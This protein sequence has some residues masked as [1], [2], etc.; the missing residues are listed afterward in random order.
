MHLNSKS[1]FL[2]RVQEAFLL[3]KINKRTSNHFI[4]VYKKF[5]SN[6]RSEADEKADELLA[7]LISQSSLKKRG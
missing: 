4:S 3:R 7:E 5:D 6:K 2:R 1:I